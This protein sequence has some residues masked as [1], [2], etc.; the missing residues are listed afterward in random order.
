MTC[1]LS[2]TPDSTHV[3]GLHPLAPYLVQL[4]AAEV[5]AHLRSL[6]HLS[7]LLA[8]LAALL[9]NPSVQMEPFLHQ[10]LPVVITCLVAK[11]L[12]VSTHLQQQHQTPTPG[13]YK[14]Q[15][16]SQRELSVPDLAAIR[17]LLL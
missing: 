13:L 14:K 2:H 8:A 6:P 7:L 12:G 4:V 3:V 11:R 1:I 16:S 15:I 9:T 5:A 17:C 10:I